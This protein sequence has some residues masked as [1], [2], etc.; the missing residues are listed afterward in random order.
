MQV[1]SVARFAIEALKRAAA[2]ALA[3]GGDRGDAGPGRRGTAGPPS[4]GV[5]D[6]VPMDG[7]PASRPAADVS[8]E[9]GAGWSLDLSDGPR[10]GA[11]RGCCADERRSE[12]RGRSGRGDPRLR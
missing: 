12:R 8:E 2:V 11:T 9:H 10:G 6:G 7:V 3:W 4:G 5:H 1:R